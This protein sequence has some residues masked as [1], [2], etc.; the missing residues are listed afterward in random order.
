M[1]FESLVERTVEG[2]ANFFVVLLLTF[3]MPFCFGPSCIRVGVIYCFGHREVS[4]CSC[5]GD[6]HEDEA[7]LG[8]DRVEEPSVV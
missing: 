8:H 5:T 7:E 3:L 1:N 4:I 6:E 2:V